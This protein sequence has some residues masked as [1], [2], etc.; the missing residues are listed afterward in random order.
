M[1]SVEIQTPDG[2]IQAPLDR[3]HLTIGRL[4]S[5]TIA[6]PYPHIS[7]QH[8]ELRLM[9]QDWWIVDLRSTNGLHVGGQRVGE[10]RLTLDAYVMLSPLVT[11]H[12]LEE[13]LLVFRECHQAPPCAVRPTLQSG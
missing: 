3:D 8:A 11:L 10:C 1:A 5:N 2:A 13:R 12:L 4:A 7:R 9:G 6:L